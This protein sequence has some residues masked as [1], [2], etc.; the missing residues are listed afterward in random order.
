MGRQSHDVTETE[1]SI[2][3]LLWDDGPST[4]RKLADQLY[5]KGG[6]SAI[7]TVQK[8][9][10]RL[11]E[12]EMVN[13]R[14]APGGQQFFATVDRETL[15]GRRLRH[16]AEQLCDGSMTPLLTHLVRQQ[17]WSEQERNALRELLR[18]LENPGPSQ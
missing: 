6:V 15:I 5:P 14:K 1:M 10:Q 11:E 17:D 7:A 12:K 2:L 9:L 18:E 4:V 16:M 3:Q 8:L 13:R